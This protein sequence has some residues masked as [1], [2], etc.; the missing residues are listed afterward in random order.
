[1]ELLIFIIALCVGGFLA[2][3]FGCDSRAPA[4]SKEEDLAGFGMR[5]ELA[6]TAPRDLPRTGVRPPMAP[7]DNPSPP[8]R[9]M[10]RTVARM[11]RALTG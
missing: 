3:R 2:R 1:M 8:R 6:D 11:V 5:W 4:E 10:G 9:P 7:S